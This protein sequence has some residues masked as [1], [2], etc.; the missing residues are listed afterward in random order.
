MKRIVGIVAL[1]ATTASLAMADVST[2]ISFRRGTSVFTNKDTSKDS[3]TFGNFGDI[4]GTDAFTF[5]A[6]NEYAGIT[7]NYNPISGGNTGPAGSSDNKEDVTAKNFWLLGNGV[8]YTAYVNPTDWL[9]FKLGVNKDG[10]M[11]AE[12]AKKDTDDT[13]WSAAGRYAFLYK[14]G[15]ATKNSTAFIMDDMTSINNAATPFF[16]ADFKFNDVGPGNLLVRASFAKTDNWLKK[17]NFKDKTVY[18]AP[19]LVVGYNIKDLINVNLDV[20]MASNNDLAAGLYASPSV[21]ENLTIVVGGTV[22]TVF[23]GKKDA[24]GVR[25]NNKDGVTFFGIDLRLR[26]V[27]G[28]FHI[29]NAFNFTGASEDGQVKQGAADNIGG[30]SARTGDSN[31][32]DSIFLTYKLNDNWMVTGNI[33][34]QACLGDDTILDLGVTPGVMYTI[35]KGAAITAGVHMGFGNLLDK[36]SEKVTVGRAIDVALP[37]IFR[38]KM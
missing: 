21:I 1:A 31:I 20:Q 33:Q 19:G 8:E 35:G 11:Y 17:G 25:A 14:L 36:T 6:S 26:Y 34:L 23:D 24:V 22:S 29:A 12:Q 7:L 2:S 28:D 32:W 16:F 38:V 5:K 13:N 30:I 3:V 9:Q 37:V 15:I 18:A 10:I 27:A 4:T